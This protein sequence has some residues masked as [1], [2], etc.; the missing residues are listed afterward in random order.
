[1][2][3]FQAAASFQLFTGREPDAERMRRHFS[4][5]VTADRS[6]ELSTGEVRP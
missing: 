4:A 6:T 5:L 1:M 3:V 2:A